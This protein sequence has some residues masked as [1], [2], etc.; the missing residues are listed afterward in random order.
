[1]QHPFHD[2]LMAQE[3][4]GLVGNFPGWLVFF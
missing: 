1:M 3:R 2:D 4:L